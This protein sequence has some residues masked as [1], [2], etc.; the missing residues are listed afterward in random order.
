M[1]E[2]TIEQNT[3]QRNDTSPI[4]CLAERYNDFAI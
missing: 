1:S 3:E 4:K 2:E